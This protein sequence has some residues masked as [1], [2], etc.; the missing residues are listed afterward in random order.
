[1]RATWRHDEINLD[2]VYLD[3]DLVLFPLAANEA[4]G[5]VQCY[6][7]DRDGEPTGKVVVQLGHVDIVRYLDC[8]P[9]AEDDHVGLRGGGRGL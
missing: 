6:Q 3:G 5:W 9:F 4:E 2:E 7:A 8:D 1:M